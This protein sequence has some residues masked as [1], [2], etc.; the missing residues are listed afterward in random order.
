MLFCLPPLN[1]PPACSLCF[2]ALILL[3]FWRF[4]GCSPPVGHQKPKRASPCFTCVMT[5]TGL[6]GYCTATGKDSR[7]GDVSRP[8]STRILPRPLHSGQWM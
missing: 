2:L 5:P 8:A 7:A 6:S 1:R 3:A 4:L